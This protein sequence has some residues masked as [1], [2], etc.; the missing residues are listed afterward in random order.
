[1]T[2]IAARRGPQRVGVGLVEV[3]HEAAAEGDVQQLG[4]AAHA[5]HRQP[6][7][8]RGADQRQLPLV[9]VGLGLAQLGMRVLAVER[10]VGV[11]AA[12]HHQPVETAD[13]VDGVGVAGELDGQ[14][15]DSS[16]PLRVLAEV[17]V[18]LLASERALGQVRDPL[19]GPTPSGEA[20]QWPPAHAVSP[21][22]AGA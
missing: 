21:R 22:S 1:M 10:R 18:D 3:L 17:E 19:D 8:E 2:A 9:A 14:P 15:A 13:H 6:S 7:F 11:G 16:D 12:G 5:Q 4:A 20:D